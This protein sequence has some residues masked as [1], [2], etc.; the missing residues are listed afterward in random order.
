MPLLTKAEGVHG[1][2]CRGCIKG[3][4][5]LTASLRVEFARATQPAYFAAVCLSMPRSLAMA[6]GV[7]PLAT[8]R[9][10]CWRISTA[11]LGLP[12]LMPLAF[13]RAIPAFERSLIFCASTFAKDESK[14]RRIL[15]TSSLP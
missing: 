4:R 8:R 5:S 11:S 6:W 2:N 3:S 13:A 10:I 7:S 9:A 12:I 1:D 15:R 14:A